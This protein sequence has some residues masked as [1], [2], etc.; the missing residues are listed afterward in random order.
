MRKAT[1][2]RKHVTIADVAK[3][4][5]VSASTVSRYINNEGMVKEATKQSIIQA[6]TD[7]DYRPSSTSNFRVPFIT[8]NVGVFVSD[9]INPF[10]GELVECIEKNLMA[11]G[12]LMTLCT[13]NTDNKVLE[14]Y[15][16]EMVDRKID[17]CIIAFARVP[18]TNLNIYSLI[19]QL[20][21]VSI[22]SVI[23]DVDLVDS[24][25]EHGTREIVEHLIALGHR[26]IA[27]LGYTDAGAFANR[28]KGYKDALAAH[29]IA[30]NDE[31]V[32]FGYPSPRY[33]YENTC[34]LIDMKDRP[35]AIH[36]FNEFTASGAYLAIR[37]KNLSI[38]HDISLTGFDGTLI[39]RLCAPSLTTVSQPISSIATIATELL[40]KNISGNLSNGRQHI[41]VPTRLVLGQSTSS[42]ASQ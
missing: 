22:Q 19:K 23:D 15:L 14:M 26:K 6:I 39:S 25:D 38:P 27:F 35:T 18:E 32:R 20:K 36:C 30:Y 2:R 7:L 28:L 17:G 34:M 5:N 40:F 10:V 29:G 41:T 9:I 31:Y 13:Y 37:D 24:A 8:K 33:G 12:Y 3:R 4:A 16:Q 1:V 11:K 21:V 42:P